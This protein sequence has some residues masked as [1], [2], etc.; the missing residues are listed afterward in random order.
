M[1][2]DFNPP[3][4]A[5]ADA[6]E[7]SGGKAMGFLDHLEELRWTLAKSLVAFSIAFVAIAIFLPRVARL[8]HWPLDR[9]M[10]EHETFTGLVTTSPLAVFSVFLQVC[11]LGALC[12]SLPFALFFLGRFVAP[13]LTSREAKLLIPACLA[14]LGLF[15]SGAA[16]AFFF[17]LPAAITVSVYFNELL[18]YELIWAADR[19]YSLLVWMVIGLGASFQFPLVIQI[20]V[21]LGILD[22]AKLRRGWPFALIG[23]FVIAALITPPDPVTQS[24]VAAPLI[25]LYQGSIIMA[26]FVERW[27]DRRLEEALGD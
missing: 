20:L 10:R 23:F 15:L 24:M 19:Y 4:P 1:E 27:R 22:T 18:G 13:A 5:D 26:R 8:L 6:A 3:D 7:E 14:T 17:L 9:A 12:C 25:L 11:L 16:L 21:Y 2:R